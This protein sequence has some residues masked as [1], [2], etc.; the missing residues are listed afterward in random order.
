MIKRIANEYVPTDV[1]IP[2]ETLREILNERSISQADLASRMGRPQKTIS[3]IMNGKAS[4]TPETALEL[5][6]VLGVQAE[7]W[8]ARERDYRTYIARREQE[9]CF[10]KEA[11]WA[12][13]FPI[14][15]MIEYGW[16][17]KHADA[18]SLV[19]NLLEFF[20]VASSRQWQKKFRRLRYRSVFPLCVAQGR[21]LC[22]R[23]AED[24]SLRSQCVRECPASGE[25]PHHKITGGILP[26]ADGPFLPGRSSNSLRSRASKIPRE[27]SDHV[28]LPR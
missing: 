1:S 27:W 25:E 4:I 7:F 19:R 23:E 21:D 8:I 24:R 13:R 6:L 12:R 20:G 9:E 26:R 17:P 22:C 5:E 15:K 14:K 10:Q 3:E 2:G 28:A 18:S 16:I 11:A